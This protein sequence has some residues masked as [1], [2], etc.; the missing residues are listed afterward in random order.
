M[1]LSKLILS[2]VMVLG[3]AFQAG[4]CIINLGDGAFYYSGL[5]ITRH[6]NLVNNYL[7]QAWPALDVSSTSLG[8]ER[9][10]L[11]NV[12]RSSVFNGS[13]PSNLNIAD[14]GPTG[15]YGLDQNGNE[16]DNPAPV[17]EPATMLLLG[18]GLIGIAGLGKK[19]KI[20]TV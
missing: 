14:L 7:S 12:L 18:A 20:K 15:S 8:S 2:I 9:G 16:N 5:T 11:T 4:A 3:F 6:Q 13:L 17:P 19:M 1:K 10:V